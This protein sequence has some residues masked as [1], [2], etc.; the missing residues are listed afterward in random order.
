MSGGRVLGFSM[1]NSLKEYKLTE[2]NES[3]RMSGSEATRKFP[4]L[5][6]S[7]IM[8]GNHEDR[9]IND[10]PARDRL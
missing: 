5:G 6:E 9:W 7:A 8:D 2:R 10:S 4:L 1:G 3:L